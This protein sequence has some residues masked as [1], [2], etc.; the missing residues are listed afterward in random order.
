MNFFY[1]EIKSFI[2]VLK[3]I[4][5]NIEKEYNLE[6]NKLE[7]IYLSPFENALKNCRK[8][9]KKSPYSIFCKENR[10]QIKLKYNNKLLEIDQDNQY[11]NK[12]EK[13]KAKFTFIIKKLSE[14][15]KKQKSM[16][17]HI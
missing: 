9:K 8:H 15:W 2:D 14:E 10:E 5:Q 7:N 16:I 6:K 11:K 13:S 17:K 1:N 12:S 3:P 4:L